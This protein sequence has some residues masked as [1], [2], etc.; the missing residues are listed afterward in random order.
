MHYISELIV[1]YFQHTIN[2]TEREALDEWTAR[3]VENRQLLE[4]LKREYQNLNENRREKELVW[5]KITD[6]LPELSVQQPASHRYSNA[7]LYTALSAAVIICLYLLMPFSFWPT[8][9]SEIVRVD[10]SPGEKKAKVQL[11]DGANVPLDSIP[12]GTIIKDGQARILKEK[13]GLLYYTSTPN[14]SGDTT[15]FNTIFTPAAGKYQ[16]ILPDG[17]K[18]WLNA[19]SSLRFP[20]A[21]GS[22]KREVI[23][24][25]QGYF[26]VQKDPSRPFFVAAA[27]QQ[28]EVLGTHFDVNAYGDDEVIK[29]TLLE[30][31]L[32]IF[33]KSK[34]SA[35]KFL[36]PILLKPGEQST[37]DHQGRFQVTIPDTGAVTSWL[38][39]LIEFENKDIKFIMRQVQRSYDVEVI[40][41]KPISTQ[42][43]N[44]I[45]DKKKSLE[46][47]LNILHMTEHVSF[48]ISGK[49][50]TV[51]SKR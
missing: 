6:R 33:S 42:K 30:G 50:V 11:S 2:S 41:Q 18:V 35:G 51:Y 10:P 26:E 4:E 39:D 29:T 23:L 43:F 5:L 46:Y 22:Q 20:V 9:R 32:R 15:L 1:K 24:T 21:F 25:G 34:Q 3:S 27:G 7:F 31:S 19:L 14:K 45:L 8:S 28:I 47:F 38:N 13:N 12:S 17:T 16:L 48:T 44:V 37:F 40:F 49:K 36:Q